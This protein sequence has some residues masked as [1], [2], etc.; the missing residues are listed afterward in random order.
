MVL[1]TVDPGRE[2]G[3]DDFVRDHPN[4][5][6]YH[7]SAWIRVLCESFG[8]EPS[9]VAVL[10]EDG[11]RIRG[12]VPAV[13]FRRPL[14][15]PRLVSLPLTAY[16]SP[17]LPSG[18]W[19][20]LVEFLVDEHPSL[21]SIELK[22]MDDHVDPARLG[23]HFAVAPLRDVTH[24]LSLKGSREE[25][26]HSF[27]ASSVRQRIRRAKREDLTFRLGAGEEDLKKSFL[28]V[29]TARRRH[30][31]PPHPYAFFQTMWGILRPLNMIL[32]PLVEH[33]GTVVGAGVVLR[34]HD[35]YHLEYSAADPSFFN[36]CVNQLLIW[37]SIKVALA[38]RAKHF[39]FGRS[40]VAN[41]SLIDFKER[42][43][44]QARSLRSLCYPSVS[45]VRGVSGALRR[46][47][48]RVNPWLPRWL[49]RLEGQIVYRNHL[50]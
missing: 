43:G 12:A 38:D 27:H 19:G 15:R 17:L 32:L 6:V 10:D 35:V 3:W 41:Q 34:W 31:L 45:R 5:R 30:G 39:D 21:A 28:L 46:V 7:H 8:F 2:R 16:C 29:S 37:E 26:L 14:T 11:G 44:A 47:G 42:W 49:L 1:T 20:D 25:L 48:A 33:Q 4:G 24:I 18:T 40:A 50:H 13:R 22:T 9:S 36:R 23:P